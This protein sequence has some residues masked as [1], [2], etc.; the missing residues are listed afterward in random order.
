MS[1]TFVRR[2][3]SASACLIAAS[4]VAAG[5]SSMGEKPTS[6]SEMKQMQAEGGS[7]AFGTPTPDMQAVLDQLA[8]MNPKP[9]D[10]LTP[11][12]ARKQPSAQM[13]AKAVAKMKGMPATPDDGVMVENRTVPGA[14]GDLDARIYTPA[15]DMTD[16]PLIVFLRGGGWVIATLDTYEGSCRA[17]A[18]MTG[19]KVIEVNYRQ[20]P[21]HKFPAAHEDSYATLEWAIDNAKSMGCDPN[22]VAVVGESAGGNMAASVCLMAR[23]RGGKEPCASVMIYP[24]AATMFDSPSKKTYM[25][26]KSLPLYT[27]MLPWFIG[28]FAPTT[29]DKNSP[30]LNLLGNNTGDLSK[31]PMAT[32]I[33]AEM[34]PL[35]SEGEAWAAKLQKAGVDCKYMNYEGVTHEF[36]GMGRVVDHAKDAETFA[37]ERLKKAFAMAPKM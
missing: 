10:T 31:F 6:K 18:Q 1:R 36:F 5:C 3:L 28:Y 26:A 25:G 35:H 2:S 12:E 11:E 4:L 34:D 16:R 15:G 21:E 32:V 29:E 19:A 8:K 33:V 13:A 17:L 9:I 24:V 22:K 20:A 14:E 23:D 37:S 27:E 30:Y 7:K